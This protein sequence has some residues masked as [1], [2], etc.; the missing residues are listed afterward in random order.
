MVAEQP[1]EAFSVVELDAETLGFLTGGRGKAR[2]GDDDPFGELT[3]RDRSYDLPYGGNV[4]FV[5][6]GVA[7]GLDGDAAAAEWRLVYGD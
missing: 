4:D 6:R 5:M 3:L 1:E 2:C 7:L